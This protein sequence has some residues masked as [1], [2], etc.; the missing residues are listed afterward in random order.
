MVNSGIM[1][2]PILHDSRMSARLDGDCPW[3]GGKK[4]LLSE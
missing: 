3:N 4:D 1:G 2:A